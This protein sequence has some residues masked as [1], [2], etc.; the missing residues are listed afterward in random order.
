MNSENI[1]QLF[2]T[3]SERKSVR[4]YGDKPI[5]NE[6]CDKIDTFIS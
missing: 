3:I 2:K 5:T 6:L 4:E 1:P